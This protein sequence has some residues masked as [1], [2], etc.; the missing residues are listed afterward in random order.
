MHIIVLWVIFYVTHV[1][2]LHQLRNWNEYSNRIIIEIENNQ[3][4]DYTYNTFQARN[5]E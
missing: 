3:D 5:G 4:Q 1:V 2:K